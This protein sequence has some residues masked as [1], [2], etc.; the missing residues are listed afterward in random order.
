MTAAVQ[1]VSLRDSPER[2]QRI[3]SHGGQPTSD[4]SAALRANH[5]SMLLLQRAAGNQAVS[6]LIG[7]AAVQRA[8]GSGCT[9]CAPCRANNEDELSSS[10]GTV[11]R[12][13]SAEGEPDLVRELARHIDAANV[14]AGQDSDRYLRASGSRESL[15]LRVRPHPRFETPD[16]LDEFVRSARHL[17]TTELDTLN[18]LGGPAGA[19]LALMTTP[20]GFPL[21]WGGR[22]GAALSLGADPAAILAE[23]M[24]M[25]AALTAQAAQ[26]PPDI[27]AKGVPIPLAELAALSTIE[28]RYAHLRAPAGNSVGDFARAT[29]RYAQF[30]YVAAFA[31]TWEKL[32]GEVRQAVDDGS[33]VPNATDY[34]D[35]VR[36]R[37]RILRDLPALAR[38]RAA[39]SEED[40]HRIEGESIGLQTAALLTGMAGGLSAG[41]SVLD[42][43]DEGVAL[44]TTA[45]RTADGI[46]AAG[47]DGDRFAMALRWLWEA[48]YAGAAAGEMIDGL[49]A[50][51]PDLLLSLG[52]MVI[53]QMIPGVNVALDVYLMYKTGRDILQQ[54]TELGLAV[55]EVFAARSVLEMQRASGRLAR[56]LTSGGIEIITT[57]VT[58]G[59]AAGAKALRTRADRIAK[60][61]GISEQEAIKKAMRESPA[62]ERAALEKT[63]DLSSQKLASRPGALRR[64]FDTARAANTLRT[65]NDEVYE[66]EI[67]L[68]N[69]HVWRK[70]RGN[71]RWCRFSSDPLCFIFGDKPG[72]NIEVF[73][74]PRKAKQ[75]FW[76]GTPGNSEFT[77][78]DPVAL[79]RADYR[80]IVYRNGYPDLAPFAVDTAILPRNQLAIKDR[81]LHNQ[82][83]DRAL[84]RTRGWLLPTGEP[85]VARAYA[86]RRNPADPLIWHHV[87][88]DNILQ[89]VPESIHRAAQHAGGFSE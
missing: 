26:L 59:I 27:A 8:C 57:L 74:A 4:D 70:Q 45:I 28:L 53:A 11:Q 15:L 73:P 76:S 83:A 79:R 88:G 61:E 12:Q 89:L 68:G 38:E 13:P 36:N 30:R 17:A 55:S 87:E 82:L 21:T 63:A 71:N 22:I 69:G 84:A 20:K 7:R 86:Y 42:A 52:A 23:A 64:E 58:E 77:P 80:P 51:G 40:L 72:A 31:F 56:I 1:R 47:S 2:R 46:V 66:A 75:G 24:A 33:Y 37:Q 49:I 6:R 9:D 78:N 67:I 48:G 3:A 85:D 44:F 60:A 19:E 18:A 81:D 43:W 41:L 16:Q 35:F 25:S 54:L 29:A 62:G 5:R 10:D 32:A 39:A 65:L 34:D 50:N 14:D